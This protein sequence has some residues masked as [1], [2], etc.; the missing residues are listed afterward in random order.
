MFY[1]PRTR[2]L[3]ASKASNL[4][5]L[6]AL[7]KNGTRRLCYVR[8]STQARARSGRV[9]EPVPARFLPVLRLKIALLCE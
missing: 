4:G 7:T 3:L 5:K 1:A 9:G 6:V 2:N 8:H